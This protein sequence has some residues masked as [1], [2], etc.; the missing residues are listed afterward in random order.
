MR[1]GLVIHTSL[2]RLAG[3]NTCLR[4]GL[5]FDLCFCYADSGTRRHIGTHGLG[6]GMTAGQRGLD[7]PRNTRRCLG[8]GGNTGVEM[9]TF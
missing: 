6:F 9:V 5:M 2:R 7:R 8:D 4:F 3:L 1:S